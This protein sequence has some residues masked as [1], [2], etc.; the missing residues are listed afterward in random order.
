MGKRRTR[1]EVGSCVE[2]RP[3]VWRLRVYIGGGRH[4]SRTFHGSEPEA[5]YEL[6]EFVNELHDSA[7]A[8]GS[9]AELVGKWLDMKEHDLSP[10][11]MRGYRLYAENYIIPHL[12]SI[13]LAELK[14]RDL[15]HL[16]QLMLAGKARKG[17]GP[18][19]P[20]TVGQVHAVIRGALQQALKWE[21][22]PANVALAASPPKLRKY[23]LRPPS[24]E[25][26]SAVFSAV[27]KDLHLTMFLR[28][29]AT[30]GARR[31]EVCA[32]RWSD[33]DLG[34][35]VVTMAH[36]AIDLPGEPVRVKGTKTERAKRLAL[37]QRTVGMLLWYRAMQAQEAHR[38]RARLVDDPF[39][40]SSQMDGG[41]PWRPNNVTRAWA[42][43]RRR[44]KLD[45]GVRLH[46][47]R[48]ALA[49]RMLAAGDDIRT[50]SGRLGHADPSTTLR[51]YA[52]WVPEKDRAAA[53]RIG[54]EF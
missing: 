52:H 14:A 1:P 11:T 19:G 27:E 45:Q 32:L 47:L 42:R 20:A 35:S 30:T 18:V 41:A 26:I 3:G 21:L 43:A 34:N 9:V 15:D 40:F 54:E 12:G 48:H 7:V 50:V 4:R 10:T 46:D 6:D 5:W 8:S 2:V 33:F 39:L 38:N 25:E 37:D 13:P 16:Y 53:D 23:E 44:A 22:V 17:A 29:S 36:G 51:V 28:L 24:V 31:G 49:T